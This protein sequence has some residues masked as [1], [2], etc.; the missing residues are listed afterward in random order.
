MVSEYDIDTLARTIYG[1]AEP[2]NHA[3]AQ[4]IAH[5][6]MNRLRH[7]QQW[8]ETIAEIC[9][10]PWQFSCWNVNDPNR[11][12]IIA[13]AGPWFDRCKDYARKVTGGAEDQTRG[14]THYYAT[15]VK[16]PKWARG[17]QPCYAVAH[18]NGHEHLFFNDIDTPAPVSARESLEQARPLNTSGTVRAAKTGIAAAGVTSVAAVIEQAEPAMPMAAMLA[19]YAP[20]ALVAVLV[21]IIGYMT[22]RRADDRAEGLR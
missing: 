16:A 21:I 4:A 11:K 10:Q 1:E 19:Q 17:H 3:D 5:V 7:P 14:A 8:P 2:E 9:M 12:R 13:A 22:W 15:Y 6:V 20:W 18:R